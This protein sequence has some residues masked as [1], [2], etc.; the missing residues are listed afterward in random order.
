MLTLLFRCEFKQLFQ[1]FANGENGMAE[2]TDRVKQIYD[3]YANENT[4]FDRIALVGCDTTN[5]KQMN[6][7]A[8]LRVFI[9]KGLGSFDG[10]FTVA[11]LNDNVASLFTEIFF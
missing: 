8:A 11:V 6:N 9:G 3:T 4:Y 10:G 2:L 1:N 7:N 5:I